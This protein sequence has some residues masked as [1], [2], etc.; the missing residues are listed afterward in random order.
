MPSLRFLHLFIF[1][2][3]LL[4]AQQGAALHTLRHVFA[5][6]SHSQDKQAPHTQDC[7]HC[8]TY[9][10]LGSA[11]NNPHFSF[12]FY[13]PQATAFA[14]SSFAFLTQHTRTATARGPPALPSLI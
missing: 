3:A 5:E 4:F 10:Q 14:A 9:T 1:I 8:T 6:Q 11:L 7:E 2:L 13:L 12:D